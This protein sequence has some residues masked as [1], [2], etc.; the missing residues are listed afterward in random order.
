MDHN[1][2]HSRIVGDH[3]RTRLPRAELGDCAVL[4]VNEVEERRG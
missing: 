3:G 1:K 2:R 4:Q